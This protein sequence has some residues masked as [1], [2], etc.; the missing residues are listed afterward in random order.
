M[1]SLRYQQRQ[2]FKRLQCSISNLL[3]LSLCL[4]LEGKKK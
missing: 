2:S 3:I 1:T 4:L